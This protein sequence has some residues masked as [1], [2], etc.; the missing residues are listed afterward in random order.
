MY[1]LLWIIF[2]AIVGW[3]ASIFT[4]NNSRNGLI[5]DIIVGLIG[6]VIGGWLG[7]RFFGVS[8]AVFTW[9][10]LLFSFIGA[11]LFLAIVNFFAGRRYR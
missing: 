10:G 11:V 5:Q 1:I 7:S 4:N 3:L 9:Q 8:I 2:G 6:S